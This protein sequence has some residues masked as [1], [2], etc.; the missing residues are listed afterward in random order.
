MRELVKMDQ[1]VL[2]VPKDFKLTNI[3]K[4]IDVGENGFRMKVN[5][6]TKGIVVNHIFHF[7]C[8]RFKI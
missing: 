7:C 6:P 5:Y 3:G 2:I 8:I 4:V 1:E